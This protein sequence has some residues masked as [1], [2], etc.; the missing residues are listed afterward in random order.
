MKT[1][2]FFFLLV[3]SR[4]TPAFAQ[5][6]IQGRIT[7]RGGMSLPGAN[8]S[9]KNTFDGASADTG[10]YF[11]FTTSD[12]GR[13]V[14]QVSFIGYKTEEKEINLASL[15]GPLNFTLET[16]AGEINS[17]VVTAGAFE[18]G[19]L[20][21]PIVLKP[22]DIATTPSAVGDIYGALTTLPG[23]QVVGNEGGL[24]VRGGEGYETKTFIDGMEVVNPYLSKMPDLP[25]RS[26][27]SPILFKGTAFSTG[28]F[29]AEYGQALS[30]A[31]NLNTVGLADKTQSGISVMSVGVNGSHSQR[32][33]NGSVSG[34]LQYLNMAPY[35]SLFTQNMKWARA[36]LQTDGTLMFRQQFGK[37]GILKVFG[38]FNLTRNALHYPSTDN[39][40]ST[41]LIGLQNRN[42]YINA[43]YHD[44]IGKNWKVMAGVAST[45]DLTSTGIAADKLDEQVKSFHQRLTFTHD[46]SSGVSVK[47]GEEASWYTYRRDYHLAF[48]EQ[49]YHWGFVLNDYAVYAEPEAH[50]TD[51]LV[52]RAGIRGEYLSL[53]HKWDFVP[54]ISMAY[55]LGNYAQVSMAYGLFHQRAENE[56]LIYNRDLASEKA[57]HLIVNYQYEVENRIFRVELY[58]KWYDN[59][60]KYTSE[61]NPDPASYNNNGYGY[62]Q[63][64]DLFWR[65]SKSIRDLDYWV[66]YSFI[67]TRRNYKN[68]GQSVCPSFIS[69]H[70]FSAVMK[71]FI[72]KANTYTGLTYTYA[73][74]KTWYNPALP[75][76]AGDQIKAFNDLSLNVIVIRPFLK[77]Y[78][79]LLL[80]VSNI[81]GFNNVFGYRYSASPD[82][83]GNYN[84]FPIK[85]Q[86]RRF[87]VVG[88]FINLK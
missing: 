62:A 61:Y 21:R 66:S 22:M 46:Y 81:L 45:Y 86:S 18:T 33:E 67:D 19:D 76:S 38:T 85:P 24:Y 43:V 7:D 71:Y 41:T 16:K 58:R 2:P 51:Q 23:T 80:N 4:L 25:T 70:T 26:R 57:T 9:L 54:R 30:S 65:D 39:P 48:S 36:P 42:F 32:W 79:A 84:L 10:G 88:A 68:F 13:Q 8:I 73:S 44:M 35:Y 37:Y 20:K 17:V 6:S 55:K 14:V 53:L 75:V 52:V 82:P 27:F 28:G 29:T 74:P 1:L 72:R 47:F 87:I 60:V 83:T 5:V 63:G 49:S 77:S 56:Y 15:A 12:T 3:L 64:I 40:D 11:S 31:I 34:T 50:V 78:C 59:L 69:P